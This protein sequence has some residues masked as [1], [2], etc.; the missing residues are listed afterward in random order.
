[1]LENLSTQRGTSLQ[2]G[3]FRGNL[4]PEILA[5]RTRANLGRERLVV[6]G[7]V[8]DK[9]SMP[10]HVLLYRRRYCVETNIHPLG[11]LKASMGPTQGIKS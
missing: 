2:S 10:L 4:A 7:T 8:K 5:R 1:M 3:E 6:P 9:N 11:S